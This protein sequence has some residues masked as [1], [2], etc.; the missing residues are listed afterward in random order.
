METASHKRWRLA[1]PHYERD[2]HRSNPKHTSAISQRS[3]L[4]TKYGLTDAIYQQMFKMQKGVCAI[5]GKPEPH[6][7]RRL[8]VDHN[9]NTTQVRG[10]LCSHCN[11]ALGLFN[12]N[13]DSLEAAKQYLLLWQQL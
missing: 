13:L 8:A 2:R 7:G 10:L 9:H 12:E 1:H 11:V 4:K 3:K 6:K 5:C